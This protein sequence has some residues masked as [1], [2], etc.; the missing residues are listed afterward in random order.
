VWD[1]GLVTTPR[2]IR[3]WDEQDAYSRWRYVLH[4]KAGEIKAV[5]AAPTSGSAG[6]GGR[7]SVTLSLTAEP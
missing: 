4:W 5:I 2:P 6:K 7:R 3:T 1:N